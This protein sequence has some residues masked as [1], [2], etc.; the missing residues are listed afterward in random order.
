MPRYL[1]ERSFPDR[2][3]I[4]TNEVGANTCS[5]V[6]ANNAEDLVTWVH[7][8]V[9]DDKTKTFCIYDAPSPEAI[10]RA[11]RR[12][13]LPVDKITEVRVLDPYFYMQC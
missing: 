3:E 7:S 12:N 8:Y 1:V 11:A 9:T 13:N 6:V 5:T 2:L 4:P 10:R